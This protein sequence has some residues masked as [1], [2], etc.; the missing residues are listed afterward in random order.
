MQTIELDFCA[1]TIS[2]DEL[3]RVVEPSSFVGLFDPE[4]PRTRDA[5]PYDAWVYVGEIDRHCIRVPTE[6]K[7]PLCN[8]INMLPRGERF[9]P[10]PDSMLLSCL[11]ASWAD[12]P[13]SGSSWH[14]DRITAQQLVEALHSAACPRLRV[15]TSGDDEPALPLPQPERLVERD[16]VWIFRTKILT[17]GITAL[18]AAPGGAAH[19]FPGFGALGEGFGIVDIPLPSRTDGIYQVRVGQ[20]FLRGIPYVGALPDQTWD[21]DKVKDVFEQTSHNFSEWFNH[22]EMWWPACA[23]SGA[24]VEV[25]VRAES[26]E[27]A[28]QAI[29]ASGLLNWHGL[30]QGRV[31]GCPLETRTFSRYAYLWHMGRANGLAHD[32]WESMETFDK[33]E[34]TRILSRLFE[35]ISYIVPLQ[36][37]PSGPKLFVGV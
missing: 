35:A 34:A 19:T 20:T 6:F 28:R 11:D 15:S 9:K 27:S 32:A 7:Q 31:T 25:F 13:E 36:S 10:H 17:R 22:I 37:H 24:A 2:S 12:S 21:D 26:V 4:D 14:S 23:L 3:V 18:R 16:T 29:A 8:A 30:V 1:F 5:E 33:A